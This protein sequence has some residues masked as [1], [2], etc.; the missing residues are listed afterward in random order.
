MLHAHALEE[1][2]SPPASP[3]GGVQSGGHCLK[4][5]HRLMVEPAGMDDLPGL[6]VVRGADRLLAATGRTRRR[7]NAVHL[8]VA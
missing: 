3:R 1:K 2:A 8:F 5:R 6:A 7:M 4:G